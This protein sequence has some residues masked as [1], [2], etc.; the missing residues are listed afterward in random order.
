MYNSLKTGNNIIATSNEKHLIDDCTK[1]LIVY[2][3]NFT[4]SKS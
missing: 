2:R 4:L 1:H 3:A